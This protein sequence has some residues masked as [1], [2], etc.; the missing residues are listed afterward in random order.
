VADGI[1]PS[2]AGRGGSVGVTLQATTGLR[3]ID[4]SELDV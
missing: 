2:N 1:T 3:R 4:S